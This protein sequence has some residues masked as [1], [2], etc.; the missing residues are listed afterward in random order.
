M[1]IKDL[2]VKI[3]ASLKLAEL[4]KRSSESTLAFR[5]LQLGKGWL[6]KYLKYDYDGN[7][8]E[9]VTKI[10]EIP[11]TKDTSTPLEESSDYLS[12][13]NNQRKYI[14]SLIEEVEELLQLNNNF[15]TSKCLNASWIEL[16]NASMWYGFE[17]QRLKRENDSK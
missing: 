9:V 2:R 1:I 6:G 17:L 3:D 5:S 14:Q 10:S 7:D 13:V 12:T 11:E 4:I 15:W 8:Y 16:N